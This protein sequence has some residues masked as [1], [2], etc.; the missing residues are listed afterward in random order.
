M[1]LNLKQVLLKIIDYSK[2]DTE[3]NAFDIY[4]KYDKIF[5]AVYTLINEQPSSIT[6]QY[7]IDR[8]KFRLF[9]L[10]KFTK[11]CN[12][13]SQYEAT[14]DTSIVINFS[15][16]PKQYFVSDVGFVDETDTR[17][18]NE[19]VR[20]LLRNV[21]EVP[22]DVII[23]V[24]EIP[25]LP[26]LPLTPPSPIVSVSRKSMFFNSNSCDIKPLVDKK[27]EIVKKF[28]EEIDNISSSVSSGKFKDFKITNL[29]NNLEKIMACVFIKCVEDIKGYND[30]KGISVDIIDTILNRKA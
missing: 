1:S 20:P 22:R 3:S 2:K 19:I 4:I 26:I 5:K 14:C 8:F 21:I 13:L 18:F 25:A 12:V 10:T 29:K 17:P 27:D 6:I 7:L 24:P 23:E 28:N 30:M 15:K 9:E 11:A 16:I